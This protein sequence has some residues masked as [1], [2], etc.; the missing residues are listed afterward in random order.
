MIKK[1]YGNRP[2]PN[3]T[4][5]PSKMLPVCLAPKPGFCIKSTALSPGLIR[6]EQQRDGDLQPIPIPP[7]RKVFVNI[8]WDANV[9]PPPPPPEDADL[10]V[11]VIVSSP[12][13]DKDKGAFHPPV[14]LSN[15]PNPTLKYMPSRQS[16]RRH[17][18]HIPYVREI[19]YPARPGVQALPSR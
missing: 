14:N 12:R 13:A 4:H 15:I 3:G 8:A 10:M 1:R 11:P 5:D 18:L 6:P 9:P 7:H 19:T 17:R 2:V 16:M